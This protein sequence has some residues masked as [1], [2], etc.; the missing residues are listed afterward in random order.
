MGGWF[1]CLGVAAEHFW[2]YKKE[3]KAYFRTRS[4]SSLY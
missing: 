4:L 3:V 2:L 1:W